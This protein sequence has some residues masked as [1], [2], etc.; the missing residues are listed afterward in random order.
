M[1]P[2]WPFPLES[3]YIEFSMEYRIAP[4]HI[5]WEDGDLMRRYRYRDNND[6]LNYYY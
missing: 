4:K 3:V 2:V 1:P 5:K 6:V